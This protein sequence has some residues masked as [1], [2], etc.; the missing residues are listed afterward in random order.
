MKKTA[1][2]AAVLLM[3]HF[4]VAKDVSEE[5]V[6]TTPLKIYSGGIGVGAARSLND[7]LKDDI[8]KNQLTLTYSSMLTIRNN[9]GLFL[10]ATLLL[11]ENS[12]GAD[13]GADFIFSESDFRP[14]AG[15][16]VGGYV[17][18]HSEKFSNDFGPSLTAHVGFTMD[19][20]E[21]VAVRVRAPFRMV[22]NE[23]NDQMAGIDVTFLFSSK[24]KNVKK[25]N[26]N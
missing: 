23:Y 6:P 22:L 21:S 10:D 16:G 18:N 7:E 9:M 14:F 4:V 17:I 2:L 20:N 5:G 25:L 19:I 15:F 26:Y 13:F 1:L 12:Y 24:Y 3:S 8:G 11:P